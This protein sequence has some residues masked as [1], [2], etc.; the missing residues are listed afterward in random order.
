MTS[1]QAT[2]AVTVP[3]VGGTYVGNASVLLTYVPDAQPPPPVPPAP[4]LRTV[5]GVPDDRSQEQVKAAFPGT[6]YTREFIPGVLSGPKSLVPAAERI[7]RPSWNAGLTPMFSFKLNLSETAG[8]KWDGPLIELAQWL[9]TQP[10]AK[11]IP[12]HEP[13]DD[14]TGREF[15]VWFNR[16]AGKMRGA[17]S[18]LKMV[19]AAMAYQ[20][21]MKSNGTS[22][23][24]GRTDT[25]GDWRAVEADVFAVDAYSGRSFQLTSILPQH[26]GF[27]R[28]MNQIVDGR[29]YMVTER[30]FETA[31]VHQERAYQIR[32]EADWLL[33]H[34]VGPRCRAWLYWNTAGTEESASL[35]LDKQ[36]GEPALR[37]AVAR[38]AG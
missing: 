6:V 3:A 12:W 9:A 19:Y 36:H 7:C 5:P 11:V 37:D 33:T 38:L 25:P 14:M 20:W 31:T 13:E 16:V 23:I 34:P 18:R 26:P 28:W 29:E 35:L 32:R 2:V 27:L 22:S 24:G 21:A 8:G 15:A 4:A 17:N 30:V 10:D 1:M